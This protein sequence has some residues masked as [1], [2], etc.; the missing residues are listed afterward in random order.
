M[1]IEGLGHESVKLF[2]D[3]G[4]VADMADV[5]RLHERR[6]ELVELERFGTRKVDNLLAGIE[7][8]RTQPL[9]RL[10]VGLNIRH[11]GPSVAKLLARHFQTM[12]ALVTA[13]PDDIAAIDGVGPTI[14]AAIRSWLDVDRNR[15][16]VDDLAS[17]GV[18]MDTDLEPS[19]SGDR[20]LDGWTVVVTGTLEGFTREVAKQALEERGAKVTG[21]VSNKTSLVVVGENPGAKRDR[22]EQLGVPIA[23]EAAFVRLLD[24]GTLD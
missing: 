6:D 8:S 24:A 9:E 13:T 10:L 3:A 4:L 7:A 21:S 2:C 5:Y 1:D 17:L 14:A 22:A 20:P 18:R 16:L 11:L 15:Q 12:D 23:D 19:R